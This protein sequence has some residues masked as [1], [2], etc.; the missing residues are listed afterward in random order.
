MT[1]FVAGWG[2]WR[3]LGLKA[4]A[5]ERVGVGFE[6]VRLL[7]PVVDVCAGQRLALDVDLDTARG[8]HA[9]S[10]AAS[11]LDGRHACARTRT[12][13]RSALDRSRSAASSARAQPESVSSTRPRAVATSRWP[14]RSS[15]ASAITSAQ[16]ARRSARRRSRAMRS[17]KIRSYSLTKTDFETAD[18]RGSGKRACQSRLSAERMAS[19]GQPA[20]SYKRIRPSSPSVSESE[21]CVSMWPGQRAVNPRLLRRTSWRRAR[22][23]S[24]CGDA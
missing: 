20:K 3:R 9:I 11:S 1:L 16:R 21:A 12:F 13:G 10:P 17:F 24:S 5:P 14:S 2:W 4:E 15:S 8:R 19:G 18:L 23:A 6:P 7:D 22:S